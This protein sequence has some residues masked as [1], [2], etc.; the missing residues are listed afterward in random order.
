MMAP[1]TPLRGEPSQPAS[2]TPS[3]TQQRESPKQAWVAPEVTELPRLTELTLQTG[4]PI[5]GGGGTGG[6]GSSVF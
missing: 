1:R 3:Q 6:G 2:G 5:W 4:D